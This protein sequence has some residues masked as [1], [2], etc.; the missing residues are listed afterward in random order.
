MK[1]AKRTI[2]FY[3]ES[4]YNTL[5]PAIQGEIKLTQDYLEKTAKQL[6]RTVGSLRQYVYDQ[7]SKLGNTSSKPTTDST[8]KSSTFRKGEFII[9]INNWEIR[10]VNGVTNLVLKFGKHN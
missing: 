1:K 10:K 9:P 8:Y 3:S 2:R 4:E 5:K 7:R 6:N